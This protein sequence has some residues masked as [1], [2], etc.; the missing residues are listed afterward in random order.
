MALGTPPGANVQWGSLLAVAQTAELELL[1]R[2]L[3][4]ARL[5]GAEAVLAGKRDGEAP[6]RAR[7]A[8]A[9]LGHAERDVARACGCRA[10]TDVS[11]RGAARVDVALAEAL[12]LDQPAP[13]AARR[14][15]VVALRERRGR[16]GRLT[17]RARGRR[18]R[19]A[20]RPAG[21]RTSASGRGCARGRRS[22]RRSSK[23]WNCLEVVRARLEVAARRIRVVARPVVVAVRVAASK[24]SVAGRRRHWTTVRAA[25]AV[26][27]DGLVA[28]MLSTGGRRVSGTVT[29]NAPPAP[30]VVSVTVVPGGPG[31][32]LVAAIEIVLPGAEVPVD[33]RREAV[34]T[35]VGR[36]GDRQGRL[37]L[38]AAARSAGSC[39]AGGRASGPRRRRASGGRTGPPTT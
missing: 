17:R 32:M 11:E 8:E 27:P 7:R 18:R 34:T 33:R 1:R 15:R 26:A 29:L 5:V 39:S 2:R 19:R 24:I 9:G 6:A 20:A 16:R 30:A 21:C 25:L 23:T 22:G 3:E 13:R 4:A 37:A 12:D 28:M 31:S 36:R 38:R 10:M 14:D 35:C